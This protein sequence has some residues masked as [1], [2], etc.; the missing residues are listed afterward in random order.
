MDNNSIFHLIIKVCRAHY[1]KTHK[2][3]KQLDLY[4]GQPP[5]LH[6]LWKKDGRTQKELSKKLNNKS[7]TTAKMV[8]RMENEGFII[9]KTD[10]EDRRLTRIYLTEKG[11]EIRQQVK[12][13]ENQIDEICVKGFTP[14]EKVLLKRFLKN[15]INNLTGDTE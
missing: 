15:I 9:K 13:I 5:L 1:K 3:L 10:P 12:E 2:L 11:K 8:K 4:R 7:A 14:E 6:L